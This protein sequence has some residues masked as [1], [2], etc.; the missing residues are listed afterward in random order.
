MSDEGLPAQEADVRRPAVAG[1]FYP[2]SAPQ[3]ARDVDAMIE[4]AA[5]VE[6][7]GRVVGL[8]EPHAGYMYSGGIAA[9]GYRQLAPGMF[10]RVV[11]VGPSHRAAFP[12]VAVWDGAAFATPLGEI[13]LDREAIAALVEADPLIVRRNAVH[14]GEHSLE[15]QLP[16][17]QRRLLDFRLVPMVMG[18]QDPATCERL[19]R[20]IARVARA[21]G[22]LLIA[23][24]DLSHYHPYEEAVALDGWALGRVADFDPEGLLAGLRQG[25]C[26]ACGGGPIAAVLIAARELGGRE[27]QVLAYGNSGDV[28]G[29]RSQVVGYPACAI[30]G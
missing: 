2:A 3:L 20:A 24:S 26:E 13:P 8:V 23:S 4:A 1:T 28:T 5:P 19:G 15:V 22:S 14:E 21:P 17:L 7:A 9:A 18:R 12:G 25:T 10:E 27:V 6:V 30:T 16:F 11:L 29:D